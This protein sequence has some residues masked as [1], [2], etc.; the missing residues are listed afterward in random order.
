M[1]HT[2]AMLAALAALIA[3][4]GQARADLNSS[5]QPPGTVLGSGIDGGGG[6]DP[7]FNFSFVANDNSV[8]V[9]GTLN[10]TDNGDGTFTAS[11]GTVTFA[12]ALSNSG[13][14]AWSGSRI[15]IRAE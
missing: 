14:M 1:K 5:G 2:F 8:I 6:A 9:S 3:V 15:R 4:S 13:T 10:A 12:G 11:V 7:M